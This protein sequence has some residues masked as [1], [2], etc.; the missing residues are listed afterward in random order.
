M[1]TLRKITLAIY[2]EVFEG[3]PGDKETRGWYNNP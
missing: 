1:Y 2:R 3:K